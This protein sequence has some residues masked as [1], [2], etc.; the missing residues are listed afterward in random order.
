VEKLR[1][2]LLNDGA[3]TEAEFVEAISALEDSAV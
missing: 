3:V 1:V 2:P